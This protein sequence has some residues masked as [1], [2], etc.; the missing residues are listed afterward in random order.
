MASV[1]RPTRARR[2]RRSRARGSS[3]SSWRAARKL[4]AA[5]GLRN[6][7][8]HEYGSLDLRLVYEAARDDLDDLLAFAA[9][10]AG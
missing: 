4:A 5:V 2:S 6:R 9:A 10:L 8:A 1:S 7:I 3:P